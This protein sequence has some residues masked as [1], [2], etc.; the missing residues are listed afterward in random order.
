MDAECVIMRGI[1]HRFFIHSKVVIVFNPGINKVI[2]ANIPQ[3][4]LIPSNDE[5]YV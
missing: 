3:Y 1:S 5:V 2:A 4:Y